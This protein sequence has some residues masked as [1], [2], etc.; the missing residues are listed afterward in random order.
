MGKAK[1]DKGISRIASGSTMGWFVRGYKN[2][3][4]FSKLYSDRKCG[5]TEKALVLARKYR[6]RLFERLKNMPQKPRKRRVVFQDSRNTTGILGVCRTAKKGPNGK[7]NECYSVSWR[8]RPGVQK[9]TSFSIRKYGEKKAFERAIAH[10]RKMIR[11]I[12]GRSIL[13]QMKTTHPNPNS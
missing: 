5:G 11:E 10:R 1:E 7:L 13:K 6:D 2:G 8:P 3:K 9:C 4:T 12:Y